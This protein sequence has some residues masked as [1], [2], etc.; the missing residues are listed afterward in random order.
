MGDLNI[1]VGDRVRIKAHT[2]LNTPAVGL[3]GVVLHIVEHSNK[4]KTNLTHEVRFSNGQDV[5]FSVEELVLLDSE[6][7]LV[8]GEA[9]WE[10]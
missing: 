5:F 10:V 2:N 6:K 3:S 4:K 7:V 8:E 9:S 1:R